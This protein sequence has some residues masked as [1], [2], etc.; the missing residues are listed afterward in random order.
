[1]YGTPQRYT[2]AV[3][4]L[5]DYYKQ[6]Q[7]CTVCIIMCIQHFVIPCIY[8][9]NI[10]TD[11]SSWEE[12]FYYKYMYTCCTC[13]PACVCIYIDCQVF[14]S[15]MYRPGPQALYLVVSWKPKGC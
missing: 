13:M 2:S 5:V 14:S 3:S 1:M 9:A 11:F 12:S 15:V 7:L 8:V 4:E 10:A 6:V